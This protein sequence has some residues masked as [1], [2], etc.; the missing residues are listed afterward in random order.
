MWRIPSL[1]END[2]AEGNTFL[3]WACSFGSSGACEC[4]TMIAPR[5]TA[6]VAT[7]GAHLRANCIGGSIVVKHLTGLMLFLRSQELLH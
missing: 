2:D 3:S 7:R 6:S 1:G 5:T 4:A